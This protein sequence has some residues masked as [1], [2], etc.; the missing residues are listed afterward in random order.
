MAIAKPKKFG[1]ILLEHGWVTKDQLQRALQNQSV[2]GGRI[3][4]CLLEMDALPEDL[5]MKALAEQTGSPAATVENLRNIPEEIH[6]LLPARVARRCRAVPFQ[7]VGNQ[8]SIALLDVR[9]LQIQDELAFVTNKRLKVFVANEARIYEAL[10]KYY[11]EECPQRFSHLIDRMNRAR[12]LWDRPEEGRA[13]TSTNQSNRMASE[14]AAAPKTIT[15]TSSVASFTQAPK[16]AETAAPGAVAEVAVVAAATEPAEAPPVSRSPTLSIPLAPEERAAL[17][18]VPAPAPALTPRDVETQ[19]LNPRDR[20]DVG[21]T[22][23]SYLSQDFSRVLLFKAVKN[24]V[25]GWMGQG[26]GVQADTL[27]VYAVQFNQ[28]SVFL[29]LKQG[30]QFFLGTL[31]PM[32][33]HRDLA[34]TWGGEVPKESLVLPIRIKD[35]VATFVYLDKGANGLSGIDIEALQRLAAKAAIAFELCIM[36]SKLKQA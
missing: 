20:D 12:Y 24:N 18:G 4:T 6:T 13:L 36:R 14:A 23:L 34:R 26:A 31:A 11:G 5:V 25:V 35:R 7:I 10:E 1:Q 21:K 27:G 9:N 28:P 17:R 29:N 3:G 2:V 33:A 8:I 15:G 16:V 22:L 19:L 32:P 30:G